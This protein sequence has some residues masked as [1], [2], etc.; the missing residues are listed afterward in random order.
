[1][2]TNMGMNTNQTN[3]QSKQIEENNL[4]VIKDELSYEALMNKK[5]DLYAQYCTNPQLKDL[6]QYGASVH[7]ENF[8]Q[9]K[10]YLESHQ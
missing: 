8:N 7:K 2:A 5:Y 10:S 9:L 6:C 4:K 3:A 1:M